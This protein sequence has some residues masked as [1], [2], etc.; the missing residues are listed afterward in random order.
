VRK[1]RHLEEGAPV[2]GEEVNRM[3][4]RILVLLVVSLMA[5]GTAATAAYAYTLD[6][7]V[8]HYRPSYNDYVLKTS[9]RHLNHTYDYWAYYDNEYDEYYCED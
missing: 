1:S 2:N 7:P 4:Q 5:L 9:S 3:R 6:H 8:C